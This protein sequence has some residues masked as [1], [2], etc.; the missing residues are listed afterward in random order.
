[1]VKLHMVPIMDTTQSCNLAALELVFR[2][3]VSLNLDTK[4]YVCIL[5]LIDYYFNFKCYYGAVVFF[6]LDINN[7]YVEVYLCL[8]SYLVVHLHLTISNKRVRS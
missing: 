3:I 2:R 8:S 5:Y 1:M 4:Y 7:L 6:C